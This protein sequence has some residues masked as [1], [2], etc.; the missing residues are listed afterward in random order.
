MGATSFMANV[1][2]FVAGRLA[3]AVVLLF[4]GFQIAVWFTLALLFVMFDKNSKKGAIARVRAFFLFSLIAL[5]GV[6]MV[7][8]A[9]FLA[10]QGIAAGLRAIRGVH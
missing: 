6:A 10:V 5:A 8:L 4:V 9:I 1:G 7:G 2:L 3:A